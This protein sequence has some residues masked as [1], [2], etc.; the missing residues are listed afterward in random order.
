M[1]SQ[2]DLSHCH[3]FLSVRTPLKEATSDSRWERTR[4]GG[5]AHFDDEQIDEG[6]TQV[7]YS[8]RGCAAALP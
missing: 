7:Q 8:D 3:F 1:S 6:L 5:V 2:R 4:D